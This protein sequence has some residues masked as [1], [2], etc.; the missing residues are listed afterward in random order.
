MC[1]SGWKY[2]CGVVIWSTSQINHIVPYYNMFRWEYVN[3]SCMCV[4]VCVNACCTCIS[5]CM[6]YLCK[7]LYVCL[8][9]I[10]EQMAQKFLS[11]FH[12]P[13][14]N[15]N[16]FRSWMIFLCLIQYL[17]FPVSVVEHFDILTIKRTIQPVVLIFIST[18]HVI[19]HLKLLSSDTC[20]KGWWFYQSKGP[21]HQRLATFVFWDTPN[22]K[23]WLLEWNLFHK[24]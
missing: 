10:H 14:M 12:H 7:W 9:T 8:C 18:L 15:F 4:P 1:Y 13:S 11:E 5:E 22:R 2:W 20:I 24:S 21:V 23:S 17:L 6:L 3:H 16:I 19:P